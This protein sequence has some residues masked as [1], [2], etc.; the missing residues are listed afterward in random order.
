MSTRTLGRAPIGVYAVLIVCSLCSALPLILVLIG[1]L[2]SNN[3]IIRDPSGFPRSLYLENYVTAWTDASLGAYFVNSAIVTVGA[4]LLAFAL[5]LPLSYALGRWRFRGAAAVLLVFTLGLMVS[6]R[7]GVLPITRMFDRWG[8][9]DTHVGLILLYAAQAAPL[10]VLI[11]STFYRELPDTLEEAAI[12]DGASD[13][14]V[15]WSVMTPLMRP[16][17]A[18]ALVL[19]VGP[20][21]NDFFLPLVLLRS[22]ENYTVPVGISTF[23]GE[24]GADRGLLYAGIVIAVTPVIVFFAFAMRQIV[25][26]LTA[27]IEK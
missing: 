11:L 6:L 16:A 10:T 21:W 25:S 8:L 14:R 4:L 2:R 9:I 12:L 1:S 18:A 17:I 3:D 24:Y 5:Y 26:G 7:L 27:G 22:T 13:V 23:F 20:I 15:F 19:A